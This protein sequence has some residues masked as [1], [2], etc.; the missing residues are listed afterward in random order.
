MFKIVKGY[1]R[2][3]L[4]VFSIIIYMIFSVFL[5]LITDINICIPCLWKIIFGINCPSCG[6]TRAFMYLIKLD[7]VNAFRAN[8]LIFIVIPSS[9]YILI[10][11][12]KEYLKK[13][14]Y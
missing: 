4:I 1:I 7:F 11:D 3:N 14:K 12:F 13:Y 2:L 5:Y 9:V 10:K 6:L 8:W